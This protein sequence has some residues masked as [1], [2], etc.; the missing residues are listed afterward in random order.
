M[1][2]PVI[3]FDLDRR[4]R[5]GGSFGVKGNRKVFKSVHLVPRNKCLET[6]VKP[7]GG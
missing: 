2:R 5:G 4:E 1:N 3:G 7:I 6:G